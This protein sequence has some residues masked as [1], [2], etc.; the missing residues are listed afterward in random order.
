MTTTA[1]SVGALLLAAL[2]SLALFL[3]PV[4]ISSAQDETE[5]DA[6]EDATDDSTE[7][8]ADDEGTRPGRGDLT[9]EEREALREEA[10]AERQAFIDDVAAELGVT[11]DELVG[12]FE[13]VMI[14]RIEAK[15]ADGTITQE[16]ADELIERIESEDSIPGLGL[17]RGFGGRGGFGHGGHGPHGRM[18]PGGDAA[19][20][21][22]DDGEI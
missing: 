10:A 18:G 20:T 6:T 14:E 12:A 5:D 9:E 22:T 19:D 15:V 3:S 17:G 7:E 21:T 2:L 4:G 11:S 16:R 1:K 13:T 8:E